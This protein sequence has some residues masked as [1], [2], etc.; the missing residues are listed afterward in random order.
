MQLCC[1][2]QPLVS[3][4]DDLAKKICLSD[5]ACKQVETHFDTI[6]GLINSNLIEYFGEQAEIKTF[7]QG[8]WSLG[9]T[10]KP[11]RGSD[12]DYDVDLVVA[13]SNVN[14]TAS[15]LKANIG[16]ILKSTKEYVGKVEEKGRA[17]CINYAN[18]HIDIVPSINN[19]DGSICITDKESN[20]SYTY[21]K[22]YPKDL[23]EWFKNKSN[24]NS[25]EYDSDLKTKPI[26]SYQRF[27]K[28]QKVV[29]I[30][31]QHRNSTCKDINEK[32]RPIS[33]LITIIAAEL[34]DEHDKTLLDALTTVTSK[35]ETYLSN[36][37]NTDGKY[38]IVNPV[39]KKEIFTDKWTDHPERQAVFLKWADQV[40]YDL[41]LQA[42][43]L[44]RV[45]YATKMEPIFGQYV[46]DFYEQLGKKHEDVQ[47]M[48][49]MRY[50]KADGVS[51]ENND[52]GEKFVRNTFWGN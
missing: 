43:T 36:H 14:I 47:A 40:Y 3:L 28:L 10:I 15:E 37:R 52:K 1:F 23:V 49:C 18:S 44:D 51:F 12:D 7:P 5:T 46:S 48:G 34:Y 30:L 26:H 41:I 22:S 38:V 9:T 2:H 17:W 29:R 13:L 50:S 32:E 21:L 33:I 6:K 42:Q 25:S 11:L 24:D 8:S 19:L 45:E 20:G 35:L 4:Y 39:N 16:A 31:K 27:T